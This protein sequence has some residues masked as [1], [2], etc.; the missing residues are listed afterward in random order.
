MIFRTTVSGGLRVRPATPVLGTSN[1]KAAV[2]PAAAAA[3]PRHPR[4]ANDQSPVPGRQ[5]YATSPDSR[6]RSVTP[7][8]DDGRVPWTELSAAGKTARAVQQTFNFG[9]VVGGLVLTVCICHP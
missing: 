3:S 6:R 9:L 4:L 7:F 5:P 2:L 8:N 1:N